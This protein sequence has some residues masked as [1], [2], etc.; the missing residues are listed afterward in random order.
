MTLIPNIKKLP[1]SEVMLVDLP[2][3]K[4]RRSE[5]EVMMVSYIFNVC[6]RYAKKARYVIVISNHGYK[7]KDGTEFINS[8]S[9]FVRLFSS[10][11]FSEEER[12]N[13]FRS[14]SL[15]VTAVPMNASY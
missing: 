15:L 12:K 1:N 13:V 7:S 4:D 5:V 11:E 14:V 8:I 10:S 6:F 9:S 2:G 3:N